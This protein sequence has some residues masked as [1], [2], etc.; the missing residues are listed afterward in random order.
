MFGKINLVNF[1]GIIDMP[2]EVKTAWH[3]A[4]ED[5]VGVSYKPL[6][7][8][9]DQVVNGV[10]YYFIAEQN[11]QTSPPFRRVVKL[12]IHADDNGVELVENSIKEIL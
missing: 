9:A 5:Y 7:Y 12:V 8:M 1:S 10:N 4:F 6:L 11:F 3:D 2:P